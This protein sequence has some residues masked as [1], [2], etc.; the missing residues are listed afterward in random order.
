VVTDGQYKLQTG[1][2]VTIVNP[3]AAKQGEQS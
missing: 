1:A 2:S 3:R